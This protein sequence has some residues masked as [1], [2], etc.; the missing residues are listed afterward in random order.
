VMCT[1]TVDDHTAADGRRRYMLGGEPIQTRDG[2]PLTDAK[3]RRSFVTSAGAGPSVGK[4][5]LM[6]YLP[7]EYANVGEELAVLYMNELFPVTVASAS[8][9][10]VFD[11]DNERVKAAGAVAA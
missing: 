8:S 10:A 4:H 9:A 2:A 7:P 6:S 1:L 11:P 5:L 3:G